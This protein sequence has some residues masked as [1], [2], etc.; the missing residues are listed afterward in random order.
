M[1]TL[2]SWQILWDASSSL[3]WRCTDITARNTAMISSSII[4]LTLRMSVWV[5]R[6]Y[7]GWRHRIHRVG[8]GAWCKVG[9]Q[10]CKRC[11]WLVISF[12]GQASSLTTCNESTTSRSDSAFKCVLEHIRPSHDCFTPSTSTNKTT[13][14]NRSNS[15]KSQGINQFLQLRIRL[16]TK[17]K[18]CDW[19]IV[20]CQCLC[21][22]HTWHWVGR[23]FQ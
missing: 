13:T 3:C 20:N 1:A 18:K 15:S 19:K 7:A 11:H 16:I 21:D 9:L 4:S 5:H 22:L 14:I 6:T 17:L 10:R 2:D 12:I 23:A 8:V